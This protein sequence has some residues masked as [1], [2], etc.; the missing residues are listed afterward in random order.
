[1]AGRLPGHVGRGHD[2]RVAGVLC[3]Q[4]RMLRRVGQGDVDDVH[5]QQ[6][7]GARVKA[8]FKNLHLRDG[9]VVLQAQRLAR[10]LAQSRHGMRQRYQ[11]GRRFS[12]RVG[13]TQ[14]VERQGAQGKPEFREADHGVA[15]PWLSGRSKVQE[16]VILPTRCCRRL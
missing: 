13:G 9:A 12:G 7:G 15:G 6:G 8:A 4:R 3:Q 16:P 5:R 14:Y 10:Q 1:M 2:V 11:V